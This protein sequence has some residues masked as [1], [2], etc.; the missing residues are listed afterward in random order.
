MRRRKAFVK[1]AGEKQGLEQ[2][3]SEVAAKP[4]GMPRFSGFL[5]KAATT[6]ERPSGLLF[7]LNFFLDMRGCIAKMNTPTFQ[8]DNVGV[9]VFE[10][11]TK[12]F[13]FLAG[14]NCR[15][16]LKSLP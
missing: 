12:I 11:M 16:A 3:C 6:L 10:R 4:P 2:G 7:S 14:R 9:F 15:F 5:P 13:T 8:D 1:D